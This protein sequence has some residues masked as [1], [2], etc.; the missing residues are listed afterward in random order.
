MS[1]QKKKLTFWQGYWIAAGALVVVAAVALGVFW[2]FMDAYE[3]S[4]PQFAVDGYLAAVTPEAISSHETAIPRACDLYLQDEEDARAVIAQSIGRLTCLRDAKQSTPEQPAYALMNGGQ[5]IGTIILTVKE[6]D[7]FGLDHWQV[8]EQTFDFS[9]LLGDTPSVTVPTGYRVFVDGRPL[10]NEYLTARKIKFRQLE[11]YYEAY[12]APTMRTY[13]TGQ[14]LG[15]PQ[16]TVR[17]LQD[18][19]VD[20]QTKEEIE[21]T[22]CN[23]GEEEIARVKTAAESFVKAYVRFTSA[24]GGRNNRYYNY[25]QLAKNMVPG[26]D[27]ARRT[28]SALDAMY[29]VGDHRAKIKGVEYHQFICLQDGVYM[30]DLTYTVNQQVK[31]GKADSSVNLRLVLTEIDGV[32]KTES[33]LTY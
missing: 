30:V 7:I 20:I 29:W 33:M 19:P 11:P 4:R 23:C 28:K 9:H 6:R 25:N 26:G 13:T 14:I 8:A 17:G 24:A 22:Y 16:V 18:E 10:G 5:R 15:T 27:L 21:A 31:K 1:K 2:A 12:N 3:R 32:L